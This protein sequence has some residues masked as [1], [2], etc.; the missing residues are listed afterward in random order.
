MLSTVWFIFISDFNTGII[1]NMKDKNDQD[2][3]NTF[4]VSIFINSFSEFRKCD[5]DA[6]VLQVLFDVFPTSIQNMRLIRN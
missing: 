5:D 4:I 6:R 2:I 3:A 1:P